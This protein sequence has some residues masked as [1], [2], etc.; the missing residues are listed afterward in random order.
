MLKGCVI[1]VLFINPFTYMHSF[2]HLGNI[3][4]ESNMNNLVFCPFLDPFRK[5]FPFFFNVLLSPDS[6]YVQ[7]ISKLKQCPPI[8]SNPQFSEAT[9]PS[10]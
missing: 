9:T 1:L 10:Y 4:L 6:E 5:S 2:I 3:N 8:N 7:V